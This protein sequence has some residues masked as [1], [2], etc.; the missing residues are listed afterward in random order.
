MQTLL[1]FTARMVFFRLHESPRYLVHAGRAQE[2]LESLQM[3]S[4]FN[5]SEL[6]LDLEDVDD[7]RPPPCDA[8]PF[9]AESPVDE[10]QN[11]PDESNALK[12]EN[13]VILDANTNSLILPTTET[14]LATQ[15]S[16]DFLRTAPSG[17]IDYHSTSESPN[18]LDGQGHSLVSP[19]AEYSPANVDGLIV[20][21]SLYT[22][23]VPELKDTHPDVSPSSLYPPPSII[24]PPRPRPRSGTGRASVASSRGSMYKVK[25]K[26]GLVLP[27]WIRKPLWA[28]LDRVSMV[29]SPEWIKTTLLVWM[30]WFA[31]SLG[32]FRY[33]SDLTR[34]WLTCFSG[35]SAYTMFNVFLPKLLETGP[36]DGIETPKTLEAS[37]WDVVIFTIGGCPGAI[38][39]SMSTTCTD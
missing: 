20:R 1:M 28:W 19:V 23:D 26:V 2:A 14:S 3:I 16:A 7:N 36:R 33:C 35:I 13:E 5:G 29:L 12:H 17:M 11:R 18:S 25:R 30:V 39:S 8:V 32:A 38:V 4:R 6:S 37:L 22:S 27:R 21:P 15:S 34:Q 31:M 10:R 9:L 24:R